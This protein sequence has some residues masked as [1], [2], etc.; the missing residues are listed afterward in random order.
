VGRGRPGARVGRAILCV[1]ALAGDAGQGPHLRLQLLRQLQEV[2]VA[3]HAGLVHEVEGPELE[4]AQGDLAAL[5]GERREQ[6]DGTGH[7]VMIRRRASSPPMRGILMSSVTTSGR[8][9]RDF[10]R[11][12]FPS[13]AVPTTSMSG[14]WKA[15]A[16]G[17]AHERGVIDDEDADHAAAFW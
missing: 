2:H 6:Q 8:R 11:P 3:A 5:A 16:P 13:T 15:S 4:A 14:R 7:S 10:S 1:D 9:A 17:L 12:S